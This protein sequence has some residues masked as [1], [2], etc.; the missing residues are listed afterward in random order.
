[1]LFQISDNVSMYF[2]VKPWIVYCKDLD[3]L[4]V[5]FR[6]SFGCKVTWMLVMSAPPFMKHLNNWS[7]TASVRSLWVEVECKVKA[8]S[9]L[10]CSVCVSHHLSLTLPPSPFLSHPV[11][12][13]LPQS[14]SMCC[15]VQPWNPLKQRQKS[16][17]KSIGWMLREQQADR[18]SRKGREN[19]G[20]K[21]NSLRLN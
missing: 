9:S 19:G 3:L 14:L 7:S 16:W 15:R 6:T 18:G 11:L 8:I 21:R 12:H 17:D 4:L 5:W 20:R 2:C 1:M 13:V 10:I